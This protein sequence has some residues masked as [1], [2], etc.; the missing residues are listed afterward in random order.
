MLGGDYD[1]VT[2][3]AALANLLTRQMRDVSHDRH[4]ETMYSATA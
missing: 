3:G 2:D 4:L 1:A